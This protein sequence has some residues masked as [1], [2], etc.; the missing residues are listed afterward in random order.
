MID[1]YVNDLLF[2][3]KNRCYFSALALALAL[4]D[5]CGAAEFSDDTPVAKRYIEWY[6]RY[7]YPFTGD[8]KEEDCA[9]LTG[10]LVYNLRNTFLHQGSPTVNRS[11]IKAEKEQV[12][13]F[14]LLLG[15]GTKIWQISSNFGVDVRQVDPEIGFVNVRLFLV[16][17]SYLC[18][19]ISDAASEYYASNRDKFSFDFSVYTQDH[20]FSRDPSVVDA[21]NRS[22]DKDPVGRMINAK[23][24]KKFDANIRHEGNITKSFF[25]K[26]KFASPMF[27]TAWYYDAHAKE[28]AELTVKADMSQVYEKFLKYL[29]I[30][31]A[32][33]DAG[34]AGVGGQSGARNQI[35]ILDAGCGSGRDSLFFIK[36]GYDV[37]MLDASAGMCCCAEELTGR[38]ALCMTFA[39]INFEK[40][41]DG[42][43][44]CASLLHVPEKALENIL[45][46]FHR[47]LRDGGVVYASWKYGETERQD[48]ARFYCDMTEEKLKNLLARVG[49]FDCLECWVAD[50]ALPSGREQKWL[51]VVMRKARESRLV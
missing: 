51:N 49:L 46:R 7:V 47:A 36:K 18:G 42:I 13:K 8:K 15:D 33:L 34:D 2:A 37:T 5:I 1:I 3:L 43:W 35:S 28:Y 31:V 38:K 27:E 29:P 22:I 6:D 10:E 50:D 17:I 26:L 23:L 48:G 11:K 45:A 14:V 16:D 9:A 39:D 30:D 25:K 12:D 40:Q 44:A 21:V 41:F 20:F 32:V 19:L 24:N 4:P